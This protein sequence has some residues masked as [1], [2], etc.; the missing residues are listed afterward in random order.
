MGHGSRHRKTSAARRAAQIAF[1]LGVLVFAGAILDFAY[2]AYEGS[3][4]YSGTFSFSPRSERTQVNTA[5]C[6]QLIAQAESHQ[7]VDAAI[8]ILAIVIVIGA[9]VRLSKASRST[10]RFVLVAEIIVVTIGAIYTILLAS[11][12]R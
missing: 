8:A 4:C 1:V 6:R 9:A 3:E 11:A 7:P 2:F 5:E 12:L 10:R